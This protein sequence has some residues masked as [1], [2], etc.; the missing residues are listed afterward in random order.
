[1]NLYLNKLK[2]MD[3]IKQ[4]KEACNIYGITN[5]IV[6]YEYVFSEFENINFQ[7][8]NKGF[9]IL[10]SIINKEIIQNIRDFWISELKKNSIISSNL[11]FGQ[12]KLYKKFF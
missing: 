7:L 9:V 12:K 1:M 2:M 3:N 4:F 6:N 11:I 8:N 10:K 5:Y